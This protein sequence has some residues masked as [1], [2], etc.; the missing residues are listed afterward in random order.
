MKLVS[1]H[2][3]LPDVFQ[4]RITSEAPAQACVPPPPHLKTGQ[5]SQKLVAIIN[6]KFPDNVLKQFYY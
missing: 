3:Q 1:I 6:M 2:T 5:I 4:R